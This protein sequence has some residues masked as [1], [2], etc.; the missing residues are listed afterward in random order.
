MA[1]PAPEPAFTEVG[2]AYP[3]RISVPMTAGQ[4]RTLRK[5]VYENDLPGSAIVRA[6]LSLATERGE[7]LSE[8]VARARLEVGE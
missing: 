2:P 8:A 3:K 1:A 6:L 7:L 5:M 4:W